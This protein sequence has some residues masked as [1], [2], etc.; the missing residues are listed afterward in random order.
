MINPQDNL[1][2]NAEPTLDSNSQI[3]LIL[4]LITG[5]FFIVIIII[6][7]SKQRTE[8]KRVDQQPQ[9]HPDDLEVLKFIEE[10]GGK[11]LELFLI[12]NGAKTESK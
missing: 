12:L 6:T 11:A 1:T 10:S 8:K 5:I 2:N 3:F 4:P 9:L 7:I